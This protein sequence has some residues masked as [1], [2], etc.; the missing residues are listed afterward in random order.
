MTTLPGKKEAR[1]LAADL[2][3]LF[4]KFP[5]KKGASV[6]PRKMFVGRS[7]AMGCQVEGE[8]YILLLQ[9]CRRRGINVSEF[10][11]KILDD[12]LKAEG[13]LK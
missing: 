5:E 10:L 7:Q 11:R 8:K 12:T 2:R 1:A 9:L 6:M 13:L 4:L 3:G